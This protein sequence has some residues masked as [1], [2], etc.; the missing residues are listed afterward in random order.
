VAAQQPA[1][2]GDGPAEQ[3]VSQ[4]TSPLLAAPI[5]DAKLLFPAPQRTINAPY[6]AALLAPAQSAR[7]SSPALM[8][9]GGAT[10]VVGAL[11]GGDEGT[12]I[13]IGGGAVALVGLW[14]YMR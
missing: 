1:T 4:A 6:R 8:L 2:A 14:R 11:V 7:S 13:M 10:M 5:A 12:V 9:I 3:V